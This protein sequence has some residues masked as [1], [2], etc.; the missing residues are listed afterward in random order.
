MTEAENVSSTIRALQKGDP[1]VF[2]AVYRQYE[3]RI[4]AF[5]L[6]MS[7]QADVAQDLSAEVWCRVVEKVHTL[8]TDSQLV[9][10]IYTIARNLYYSYCRSRH[11]DEHYL[12]ELGWIHVQTERV[13]SPLLQGIHR[14]QSARLEAA[15]A[16]LTPKYRETVILVGIEGLS[17][18]QA[19]EVCATKAEVMRQ[20]F[21]RAVR[22]LQ[23]SMKPHNTGGEW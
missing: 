3:P 21:S 4:R 5:L 16:G 19:A 20:R 2:S 7:R 12:N 1:E 8:N 17:Y 15:L 23:R 6:R 13:D 10:W 9:P 14:E 18:T 11:R 22:I